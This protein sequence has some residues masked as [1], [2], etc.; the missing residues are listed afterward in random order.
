VIA[1][2]A[3][4]RFLD[5]TAWSIA[6]PAMFPTVAAMSANITITANVSGRM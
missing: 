5:A 3:S 4:T 1:N 6:S 2:S